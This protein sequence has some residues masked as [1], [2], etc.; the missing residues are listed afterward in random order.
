MVIAKITGRNI[1]LSRSPVTLRILKHAYGT[2][3][4]A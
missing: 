4:T 1:G 2:E 3:V